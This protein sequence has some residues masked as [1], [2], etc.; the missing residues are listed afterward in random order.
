MYVVM[1]M[2]GY[3]RTNNLYAGKIVGYLNNVVG[4]QHL[5]ASCRIRQGGSQKLKD[6][7]SS[8]ERQRDRCKNAGSRQLSFS[9]SGVNSFRAWIYRVQSGGKMQDA[10]RTFRSRPQSGGKYIC[11][12][13]W[14]ARVSCVSRAPPIKFHLHGLDQR[15]SYRMVELQLRS[16]DRCAMRA[17]VQGV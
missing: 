2:L 8:G 16:M 9:A 3:L 6:Y 14:G 5:S 7:G 10:A 11:R 17:G 15:C 13:S 1:G 4:W 12:R